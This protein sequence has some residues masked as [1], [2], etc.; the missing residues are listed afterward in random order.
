VSYETLRLPNFL[1][2]RRA[3]KRREFW[4]SV[5]II[6]RHARG[7]LIRPAERARSVTLAIY[8]SRYDLDAIDEERFL[9]QLCAAGLL[10]DF[11]PPWGT[12]AGGT[13]KAGGDVLVTVVTLEDVPCEVM[14]FHMEGRMRLNL[15][16]FVPPSRHTRLDPAAFGRMVAVI[17]DAAARQDITLATTPRS[18]AVTIEGGDVESKLV[19]RYSTDTRTLK[20]AMVKAGLLVDEASTRCRVQFRSIAYG[21]ATVVE[22]FDAPAPAPAVAVR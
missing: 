19:H 4:R 14:A 6:R 8:G 11:I 12:Y 9:R 10:M 7:Q 2:P 17:R 1:P 20:R 15:P 18:M 5:D 16:G 22:L 21:T 3:G 13:V